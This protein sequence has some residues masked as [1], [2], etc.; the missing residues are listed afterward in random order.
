MF[1][2]DVSQLLTLKKKKKP[3]EFKMLT[4]DLIIDEADVAQ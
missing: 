1:P 4:W 3:T 2:G